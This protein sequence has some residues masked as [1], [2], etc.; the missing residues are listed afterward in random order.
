M[1][2]Y[3]F[4]IFLNPRVESSFLFSVFFIQNVFVV[5]PILFIHDVFGLPLARLHVLNSFIYNTGAPLVA[6]PRPR[7]M[8]R[9]P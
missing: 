1:L 3:F 7:E 6:F 8:L 2:L 5:S 9:W 4:S